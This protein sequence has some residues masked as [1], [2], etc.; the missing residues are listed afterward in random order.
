[1][2]V[3]P[4]VDRADEMAD[5]GCLERFREAIG[6][7]YEDSVLVITTLIPTEASWEQRKDREVICIAYHFDWDKLTGTVL[8]RGW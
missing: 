8:N 2:S 3:W 1:M 5:A 6:V 7:D 4:G